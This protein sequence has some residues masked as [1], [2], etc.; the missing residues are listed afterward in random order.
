MHGYIIGETCRGCYAINNG[1]GYSGSSR[2]PYHLSFNVLFPPSSRVIAGTGPDQY[3]GPKWVVNNYG[4]KVTNILKSGGVAE[5]FLAGSNHLWQAI[6]SSS[7][8][9]YHEPLENCRERLEGHREQTNFYHLVV[10]MLMY[11]DRT[12]KFG[13]KTYKGLLLLIVL[14]V[15]SV[16]SLS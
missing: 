4:F 15:E 10:G 6:P 3:C 12:T 13:Y 9:F 5:R 14:L 1:S 7:R 8:S 16:T 2:L 11:V